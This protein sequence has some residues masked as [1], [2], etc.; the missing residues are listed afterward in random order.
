M[1]PSTDRPVSRPIA[2]ASRAVIDPAVGMGRDVL[3]AMWHTLG[4]LARRRVPLQELVE[5]LPR[6]HKC[7]RDHRCERTV[8]EMAG[9]L[10]RLQEHYAAREGI[11]FINREDGVIIYFNDR[12]RRQVRSSNTEP[13]IRIIAEDS[14]KEAAVRLCSR[15]L[16]EIRSMMS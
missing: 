3:V 11:H 14:S 1:R 15:F 5:E 12:T 13:I 8:G 6:Y 7:N 4:A 2:R 9:L 16:D 10:Q